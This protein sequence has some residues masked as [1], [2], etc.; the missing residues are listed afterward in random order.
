MIHCI[1]YHSFLSSVFTCQEYPHHYDFKAQDCN[2]V[3]IGYHTLTLAQIESTLLSAC[4]ILP[5]I[6]NIGTEQTQGRQGEGK[7]LETRLKQGTCSYFIIGL[8]CASTMGL[9]QKAPQSRL[10]QKLHCVQRL[11]ARI[12]AAPSGSPQ[13]ELTVRR[14]DREPSGSPARRARENW[15]RRLPRL[16]SSCL[17]LGGFFGPSHRHQWEYEASQGLKGTSRRERR[18]ASAAAQETFRAPP[19]KT[20]GGCVGRAPIYVTAASD[21][22]IG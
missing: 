12:R 15:R 21:N 17:P 5:P 2:S 6:Q 19:L 8:G 22:G 18:T 13:S 9:G 14:G 3:V 4:R 20:R 1:T 10:P 16:D 11:K 7:E